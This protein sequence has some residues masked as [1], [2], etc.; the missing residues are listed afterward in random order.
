MQENANDLDPVLQGLKYKNTK[1]NTRC[2]NTYNESNN[3]TLVYHYYCKKDHCY[4]IYIR[5][6]YIVLQEVNVLFLYKKPNLGI[7]SSR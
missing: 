5:D 2:E 7:P 4:L 1:R 3:I 6:E